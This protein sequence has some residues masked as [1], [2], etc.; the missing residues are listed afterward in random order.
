MHV[1]L[2]TYILNISWFTVTFYIYFFFFNYI[3]HLH[4]FFYIALSILCLKFELLYEQNFSWLRRVT[5]ECYWEVLCW[6]LW[7]FVYWYPVSLPPPP[8]SLPFSCGFAE[9][10]TSI[11]T[12]QSLCIYHK[13]EIRCLNNYWCV[14]CD[15][16]RG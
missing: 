13:R 12:Q 3:L 11:Y 5:K 4:F 1:T 15:I 14:V 2:H 9:P 8:F 7:L 16:G 10:G 6:G